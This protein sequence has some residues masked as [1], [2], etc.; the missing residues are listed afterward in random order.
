MNILTKIILVA[1]LTIATPVYAR[2]IFGKIIGEVIGEVIGGVMG[3]IIGKEVTSS[4]SIDNNELVKIADKINK[5]LPMM[6]DKETRADKVEVGSGLRLNY[7]YTYPNYSSREIDPNWI[8]ANLKPDVKKNICTKEKTKV[9]LQLGVTSGY[10]YRGNNGVEITRFEISKNDC[11]NLTNAASIE[12]PT[13]NAVPSA[14]VPQAQ[15]IGCVGDCTNGYGTYTSSNGFKITGEWR[16]GQPFVLGSTTNQPQPTPQATQQDRAIQK[17]EALARKQAKKQAQAEALAR[18]QE[19]IQTQIQEQTESFSSPVQIQTWV[20]PETN[21][22][23]LSLR[24]KAEANSRDFSQY[25]QD[26]DKKQ[27]AERRAWSERQAEA[28]IRTELQ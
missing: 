10:V 17:A 18:K 28:R 7:F 12:P 11:N 15:A 16:N 5:Q 3:K 21:S 19:E 1:L 4:Q 9:L 2:G 22:K 24:E 25:Q 20:Q 13:V 14:N 27:S 8:Q 26:N 6:V 23:T